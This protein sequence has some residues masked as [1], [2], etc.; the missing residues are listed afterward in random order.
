MVSLALAINEMSFQKHKFLAESHY[1]CDECA[2]LLSG[3]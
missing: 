2:T 3:S 1:G